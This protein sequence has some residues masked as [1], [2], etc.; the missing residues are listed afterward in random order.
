VRENHAVTWR[1]GARHLSTAS[2]RLRGPGWHSRLRARDTR[3][4]AS[5]FPASSQVLWPFPV[6][7]ACLRIPDACVPEPTR[8]LFYEDEG[9]RIQPHAIPDA[10]DRA[11]GRNHAIAILGV[12]VRTE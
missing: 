3:N 8:L 1:C 5:T 7:R 2:A 4:R 11:T 9:A 6:A 12:S 10:D